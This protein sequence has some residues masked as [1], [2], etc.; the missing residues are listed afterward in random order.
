MSLLELFTGVMSGSEEFY[1]TLDVS[2]QA[3]DFA[4][5]LLII[6]F[7]YLTGWT[8]RAETSTLFKAIWIINLFVFTNGLI[9]MLVKLYGRYF[10]YGTF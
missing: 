8:Y 4:W 10:V 1:R 7:S 5:A 9:H 2:S 6:S 3:K